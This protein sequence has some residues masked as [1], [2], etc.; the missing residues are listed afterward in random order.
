[1]VEHRW[2]IVAIALCLQCGGSKEPAAPVEEPL[3]PESME[4]TSAPPA[5]EEAAEPTEPAAESEA[6]E[7]KEESPPA[8]TKKPC[9]ELKQGDCKV[10]LGCAWSDKKKCV[11]EG[12]S[13]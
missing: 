13:E 6:P 11:E 10:T 5:G 2:S 7:A 9:A 3:E 1:M 8:E 4:E 12:S